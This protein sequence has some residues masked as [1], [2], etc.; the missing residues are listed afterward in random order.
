V[1]PKLLVVASVGVLLLVLIV[2]GVVLPVTRDR[3]P[4]D[5]EG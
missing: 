3:G 5:G 4:R 1:D 2:L